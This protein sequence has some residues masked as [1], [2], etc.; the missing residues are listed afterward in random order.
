MPLDHR[1]SRQPK[2]PRT[3]KPNTAFHRP[4]VH[5]GSVE[6]VRLTE[7]NRATSLSS[8]EHIRHNLQNS[9]TVLHPLMEVTGPGPLRSRH[10]VTTYPNPSGV[11]EPV[12][13]QTG[14]PIDHPEFITRDRHATRWT[15]PGRGGF[16]IL[17]FSRDCG[18]G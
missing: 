2:R 13:S 4:F 17:R 7:I 3:A 15:T 12:S 16:R 9:A 18:I 6:K 1:S 10:R 8:V 11:V 5:I 14:A